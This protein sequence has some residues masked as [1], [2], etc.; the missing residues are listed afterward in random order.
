MT[1]G[2]EKKKAFNPETW[3]KEHQR[4]IRRSAKD[5]EELMR[6]AER[7]AVRIAE[8]VGVDSPAGRKRME[9]LMKKL[10]SEIEVRIE[11]GSKTEWERAC[12]KND[13]LIASIAALSALKAEQIERYQQ[14]NLEAL[15]A[16][17]MRKTGGLGLSDRVWKVTEQFKQELGLALE[18]GIGEGKSAAELTKDVRRYLNEPNRLFRRVRSRK[19]GPLRLSKAAAAY[20][21]GRGKYRSSYKNA[22]RMT[23]TE[24]NMAYRSAD[25]ERW[26]Q[27]DSVVGIEVQLSNNHTIKDA[28]GKLRPLTDICD[29]LAGKY[30]KEFKFVGW[31]PLCRCRAVPIMKTQEEIIEDTKRILA[32]KKPLPPSSSKNYV[33]EPHEGFSKWAK[34]NAER[35]EAARGRDKLPY[36]VR[37][38]DKY[39]GGKEAS[40]GNAAAAVV[41]SQIMAQSP[42]LTIQERAAI[43]HQARTEEQV[44]DIRER[45]WMRWEP[46]DLA[47]AEK[48]AN[49]RAYMNIEKSLGVN[50]GLP[51]NF[52][53]ANE[54]KG[55]PHFKEDK[56]YRINCQT[57]VVANELRRRGFNVEALGN[58][59]GSALE[60]LSHDTSEAWRDGAGVKPDKV[61]I[62]AKLVEVSW[63]N[64]TYKVW[65]KTV[66]T[67]KA[68]ADEVG[69]AIMSKG[70]GRY[71]L[72]WTWNNGRAGHIITAEMARGEV[73]YYDPQSG[74]VYEDLTKTDWWK[75]IQLRTGVNLLKVDGLRPNTAVIGKVLT[76]AGAKMMEGEAAKDVATMGHRNF[77]IIREIQ[78]SERFAISTKLKPLGN[79]QTSFLKRTSDSRKAIINHA[80]NAAEM[81]AAEYAWNNPSCLRFK[82]VSAL[83]DGKDM[84]APRDI[85]NKSNL[86]KL[87]NLTK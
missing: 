70:D 39:F 83:G 53:D 43:R 54:M 85:A 41:S 86:S 31:H 59:K 22:L 21:P 72:D 7:E 69:S 14:R 27:M 61:T 32:G 62:G 26:G 3:E 17:N 34:D 13:A 66:K 56:K 28:K 40:A 29:T 79:L 64:R 48:L 25:W 15:K 38:N 9:A 68:L 82:R 8:S 51:M 74:C 16:F 30:P 73:K 60:K 1:G 36:F 67:R 63:N 42:R 65:D 12:A 5:V 57:A 11:N 78:K 81:D 77:K 20:H 71:H 18:E 44:K 50:R 80:F 84:E 10:A 55:N 75:N 45:Y 46:D 58:T 52:K 2:D 33:K 19:D 76:K 87:Y 49:V 4:G 37:D 35:I 24:G 6:A 23:A 47:E